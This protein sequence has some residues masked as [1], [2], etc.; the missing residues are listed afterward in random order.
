MP[1]S[2]LLDHEPETNVLLPTHHDD[3]HL[4]RE[5]FDLSFQFMKDALRKGCDVAQ[6][7]N[8][9]MMVTEMKVVTYRYRWDETKQRFERYNPGTR[10][11]RKK[12]DD[13]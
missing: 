4:D 7:P 2:T 6:L 8:G 11:Q 3:T 1:S 9:D 10:R 5:Y 13:S 12:T